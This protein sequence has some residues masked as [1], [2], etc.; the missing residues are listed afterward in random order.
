MDRMDIRHKI[1]VVDDE[2]VLLDAVSRILRK[3]GYDFDL[4]D[5]GED[6]KKQIDNFYYDVVLLDL[7]LP[8][9]PGQELLEFILNKAPDTKVV[10]ITGHA[11][12]ANAVSTIK[13]GAADFIAKP[14]APEELRRVLGRLLK[15]INLL[16]ENELLRRKIEGQDEGQM[17]VGES[18]AMR[19]VLDLVEKVAP[20]DS[21]VLIL[22]ESGTGKELIARAIHQ[23]SKRNENV[24][25][26]ID[27]TSLVETLL[28]SELFGHVK[29]SFTGALETKH[30][31]F[32][33][34]RGGTML[35]DEVGNL[36]ISI[37]AK[38]LRVLQTRMFSQVG[39]TKTIQ[40]DVRIIAA[41]NQDLKMLIEKGKFREDLFF[42][43]NVVPIY[44]PP[45]SKRVDD[46]SLLANYFLERYNRKRST[47]IRSISPEVIEVLQTYHWPGNVRELENTIERAMVF[48]ESDFLTSKSLPMQVAGDQ[49]EKRTSRP[50]AMEDMEREHIAFVLDLA[51]GN[52]SR[53]ATLLGITRKTL[54]NKLDKYKLK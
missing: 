10:I 32:E 4:V 47:P 18:R 25:V 22:G 34:A 46:V 48:E 6:C 27:C 5:N 8:D 36:P 51:K 35:F 14:F 11:T 31:Y 21:T 15:E 44:L 1:L 33:L 30:G 54:Y 20:T 41:T 28:E 13:S 52:R 37:Q 17:I 2:K 50:L 16:R 38:L 40:A 29:G 9:I 42:R 53:T 23:R 7:S 26:P 12:L 3:G 24:F 45:L 39:S 49:K 43:L 19:Q